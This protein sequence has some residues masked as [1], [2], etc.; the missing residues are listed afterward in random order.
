MENPE[1]GVI[2]KFAYKIQIKQIQT[3][4]NKQQ[5][6]DCAKM[7]TRCPTELK[8]ARKSFLK[9]IVLSAKC[10]FQLSGHVNRQNLRFWADDNPYAVVDSPIT[11]EKV[12][13]WVGIGHAGI[14]GPY[15]LKIKTGKAETIDSA[16][17][18]E[19]LKK[20]IIPALKRK[21]I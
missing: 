11:K 17:Y 10:H 18:V 3:P 8:E 5:R 21:T 7:L 6:L 1:T 16:N 14:F 15:F 9:K 13:V 2:K 12:T 20:K 19:M 4:Q